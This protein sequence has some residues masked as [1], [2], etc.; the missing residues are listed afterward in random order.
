MTTLIK[1]TIDN[2]VHCPEPAVKIDERMMVNCL[3][4]LHHQV[5][6]ENYPLSAKEAVLLDDLYSKVC[7]QLDMPKKYDFHQL[8]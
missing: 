2:L 5:A 8:R 3:E 1:M 7:T 6:K 4:A